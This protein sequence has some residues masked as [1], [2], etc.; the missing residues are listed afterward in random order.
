MLISL[1]SSFVHSSV[2]NLEEFADVTLLYFLNGK[3]EGKKERRE[4]VLIKA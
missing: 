3:R 4:I 2:E 1:P